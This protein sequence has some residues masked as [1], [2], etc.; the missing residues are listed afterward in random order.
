VVKDIN[1]DFGI[2]PLTPNN[3]NYSKSDLKQ[4]EYY[5]S[6][7]VCIGTVFNNGMPSPYDNGFLNV[8]DDCT[9][10]DIWNVFNDHLNP[11]MYNSIRN[12]QYEFMVKNHRYTEDPTYINQLLKVFV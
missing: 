3:F 7:S 4:I 6:G 1:A 11:D 12:K 9:V 2:C 8:K 10:D 5:A